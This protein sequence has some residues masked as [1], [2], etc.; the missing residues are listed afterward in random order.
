MPQSNNDEYSRLLEQQDVVLGVIEE[1]VKFEHGLSNS[2]DTMG[3]VLRA[4]TT[5][6][7]DIRTMRGALLET[8]SVLTSRKSGQI[9]LKELCLKKCELEE[10]IRILH[11]LEMLKVKLLAGLVLFLLI[12]Y[13]M[14][15]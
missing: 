3:D 2:V 5:S 6:R 15:R 13:R 1:V 8:Q 12:F 14:P 9:P 10:S 4:Y 11:Q 7:E